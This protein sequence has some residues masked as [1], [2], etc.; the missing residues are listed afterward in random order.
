M[1]HSVLSLIII[2]MAMAQGLSQEFVQVSVGAGYGQMAFYRLSDDQ[3]T[4]VNNNSWDLAFSTIGQTDAAIHV[5]EASSTIMGMPAPELEVYLAPIGDFEETIT[6]DQ[7]TERLYNDE[8]SWELGALN[9]VADPGNPFDFGWGVYN[10]MNHTLTGARIFA[11]KLRT[12]AYVKFEITS[13][14]NGIYTLRYANLDGSGETTATINKAQ[15][16]G[17]PLAFFSFV[18]GATLATPQAQW[19]L[20]FCRYVT[21]LDDGMGGVLDYAVTGVLSGHDIEVARAVN[22][23]P[24][25]VSIDTYRDSFETRLD[26]IGYDWKTFDFT[27]GWI[28]ST[29]RAYFVK[30]ADQHVWKVVF[31]DFEGS[32]TGM[33]TFTKTDLGILSS[34]QGELKE[35]SYMSVFPNPTGGE[36]ATLTF[37]ADQ[38]MED[39]TITISDLYGRRLWQTTT[40]VAPGFYTT[41]LPVE[42][43]PAG[44]YCV[45]LQ[46]GARSATVKLICH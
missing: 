31:V 5:N 42:G 43:W 17:S 4:A 6:A 3:T 29:D 10:P 27:A 36:Q 1:K 23:D 39:F 22:I 21:P 25:T 12:G 14:A 7:L 40:R 11:A 18:S 44:I 34:V 28:V 13:L 26:V 45:T 41:E 16:G 19:D 46:Q 38:A 32:S 30:T 20:L 8:S 2:T 35:V 37:Q 9:G 15:S 24:E 33:S